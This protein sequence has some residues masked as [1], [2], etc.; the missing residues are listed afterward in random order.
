MSRPVGADSFLAMATPAGMNQRLQGFDSGVLAPLVAVAGLAGL[1]A[2]NADGSLL[3]PAYAAAALELAPFVAWCRWR[4]RAPAAH[5]THEDAGRG[6]RRW[7]I[8]TALA[9][10]ALSL[11]ARQPWLAIHACGAYA[12]ARMGLGWLADLYQRLDGAI[13]RPLAL[14]QQ[15]LVPWLGLFLCG[16]AV[17]AMPI[18][19]QSGIPDYRHNFT[20]HVV[21]SYFDAVSACCLVGTLI[22][23]LGEDHTRFGQV[24]VWALTTL[25]GMGF[26]A[27]GL[28]AMRPFMGRRLRLAHTLWLAG[29]LQAAA[30]A[31]MS[32]RWHESD[33]AGPAARLWWGIVHAASAMWSSGLTMRTDGLAAY[34]RDPVVFTAITTLCVIGSLGLPATIELMLGPP[35][36]AGEAGRHRLRSRRPHPGAQPEST[37]PSQPAQE[38]PPWRR[39]ACWEAPLAVAFMCACV[40]LLYTF[41]HPDS[42]VSAW[43]PP[44]PFE[45]EGQHVLRELSN[46]DRWRMGVL[47]S[48]T[49]RSAGL[50]SI[51][52]VEG[53]ITW[54]SYA[55]FL[56]SMGLGGSAG[57]TAGGAY[58]TSILMIGVCLVG[59]RAFGSLPGGTAIRVM[60]LRRTAGF[61]AAWIGFNAL[62]A[63]LLS[64]TSAATA[65]ECVFDAAAAANGAGLSTGLVPHLTWAGRLTM[66]V[67]LIVGR[68]APVWFW[69]DM[70]RRMLAAADGDLDRR[71]VPSP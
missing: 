4:C 36:I 44:R 26:C 30:A 20:S 68:W 69:L 24:V 11:W 63:L 64:L 21:A 54:A 67:V 60:L 18:A 46:A 13:D 56:V 71:A 48:T 66:I 5:S 14:A 12:L 10:V 17:L 3:I 70:S 16:G 28:A 1:L 33:A 2:R 32:W 57:S 7:V 39:L 53:T 62:A 40:P 34:Y 52:L 9:G 49:L 61:V 19:T 6:E 45:L 42:P 43:S 35:R 31:I 41:E 59:R 38:A 23:S 25:S 37:E 27:A 55:L 22:Y 29:A 58:T 15:L 65:Y 51:P 50:Q 8:L 47:I